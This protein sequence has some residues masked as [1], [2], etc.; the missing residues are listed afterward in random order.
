MHALRIDSMD[1]RPWL[2]C[3]YVYVYIA[4]LARTGLF[5]VSFTFFQLLCLS[6]DISKTWLLGAGLSPLTDPVCVMLWYLSEEAEAS[7]PQAGMTGTGCA[8]DGE[9]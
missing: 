1:Y 2:S 7:E 3:N 4:W 9:I 6:P 8:E 5:L